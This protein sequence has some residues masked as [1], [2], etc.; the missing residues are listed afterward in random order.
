MR[1]T[2]AISIAEEL[3]RRIARGILHPGEHLIE[4]ALA[5]EFNT[6]RAPVREALIMM[7][8]DRLVERIPHHGVVVRNFT[9]QEI[10]DLYDAIYRLEEIVMD[11]AVER[12]ITEEISKLETILQMQSIT[13][14]EQ[15]VH[16]FYELNEDFH[17]LLFQIAGNQVL[18]EIYQSLR[19]SA[20]PFRILTMAQG[21]NLS[22]SYHE[23]ENQVRALKERNAEAGKMAIREQ[24]HR[25][26]RSLDLLFPN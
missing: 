19:R 23:H 1:K 21:N 6:S 16:T 26:L 9:K 24:E 7:E 10:H 13:S 12:I 15:D 2:A 11:K 25:A 22:L 8:R 3:S 18:I 5:E 20:R 4:T 14:M 17:N